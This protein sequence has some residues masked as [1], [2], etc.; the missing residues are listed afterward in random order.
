M[1][2]NATPA[3]VQSVFNEIFRVLKHSGKYFSISDEVVELR[4]PLLESYAPAH[5]WNISY[6]EINSEGALGCFLYTMTKTGKE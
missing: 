2:G 3:D 6:S 1:Y 5:K 4:L